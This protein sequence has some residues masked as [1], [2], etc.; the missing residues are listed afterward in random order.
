MHKASTSIRLNHYLWLCRIFQL[1]LPLQ[2]KNVGIV[3]ILPESKCQLFPMKYVLACNRQT[4]TSYF[5]V[6]T[7]RLQWR[8]LVTRMG[9]SP[10][11]SWFSGWW[12][13]NAISYPSRCLTLVCFFSFTCCPCFW[14]LF[15]LRM[16]VAF[17]VV[18]RNESC[19]S[20]N[21]EI[22]QGMSPY[23][24]RKWRE[25]DRKTKIKRSTGGK[26]QRSVSWRV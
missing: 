18:C 4:N 14:R 23:Q 1:L 15:P 17:P 25:N 24:F 12:E 5:T 2:K 19:V 10:F 7:T 3:D 22:K 26:M 11:Y 13:W 6:L 8:S 9:I 21:W 20:F 16:V